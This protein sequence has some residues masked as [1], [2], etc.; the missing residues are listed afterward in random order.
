MELM[1]G[2]NYS[3]LPPVKLRRAAVTRVGENLYIF[4]YTIR[5]C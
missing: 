2:M 3:R 5:N 1:Q 4:G